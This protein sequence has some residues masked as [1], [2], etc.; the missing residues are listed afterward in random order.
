MFPLFLLLLFSVASGQNYTHILTTSSSIPTSSPT[1]DPLDMFEQPIPAFSLGRGLILLQ[2]VTNSSECA[3][4]CIQM[5][6]GNLCN[7]FDYHPQEHLCDL[8][9][10]FFS[11][12]TKLKPSVDYQYYRRIYPNHLA[13]FDPKCPQILPCFCNHLGNKYK[14]YYVMNG[15]CI[16]CICKKEVNQSICF[17]RDKC[18][19]LEDE[20]KII[21]RDINECLYCSCEQLELHRNTDNV[22]Y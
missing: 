19:C 20:I 18:D 10:H 3:H 14:N 11:S 22:D 12:D 17:P 5:G 16:D 9:M 6:D 13:K 1:L 21:K 2:N 8:N 15:Q 4:H 7:S